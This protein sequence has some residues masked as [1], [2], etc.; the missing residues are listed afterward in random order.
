MP[1][2]CS[3]TMITLLADRP[4]RM[5]A[6][7]IATSRRNDVRPVNSG[8]GEPAPG[9]Y[10]LRIGSIYKEVNLVYVKRV[11]F[12][13]SLYS[14]LAQSAPLTMATLLP[15]S[16]QAILMPQCPATPPSSAR[17]RLHPR[18]NKGR[19]AAHTNT[20]C[21][22]LSPPPIFL[23]ALVFTACRQNTCPQPC[24]GWLSR[25]HGKA[26]YCFNRARRSRA[27]LRTM[28]CV[29]VGVCKC[30]QSS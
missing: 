4:W 2:P 22:Q 30:L 17:A 28:I 13:T 24:G 27:Q 18:L 6:I 7:A 9:E 8:G 1:T 3:P 23:M 14:A 26:I 10:G 21:L 15:T 12:L 11:T 29:H 25:K 20:P 19:M 16:I 5:R